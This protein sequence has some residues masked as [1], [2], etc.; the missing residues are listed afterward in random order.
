MKIF[1]G[2]IIFLIIISLVLGQ[3]VS[4]AQQASVLGLPKPGTMVNLSPSY[5][6][7]IVK[8][9]RVHP[10]NPILFDFILDT[11]NS[12]LGV[13]STQLH[14]ESEKLIKY[15]L[16]S[17]T[18]PEDDLWVNLSPYEKK[19][20][21]P[22]QLGQTVMGR[23]MLAEDYILKQLTASLIYPEKD[24]GKKF[25]NRVYTKAQNIF[26]SSD[27]PVN[28]FNK[29]WIVA[30]KA[31]VYVHDNTAFVVAC[32]MKVMLEQDYLSMYKHEQAG[33][34][35][36][37]NAIGSQVVREVVLPELEK[38]VNS[39]KNFANLRQIFN[40]MILAAW[41]KKNLKQALLN[42]VYSNKAKINGID[43]Q[44]KTI[45]EQIYQEYLKAYKKGV[46]NYIK[47]D[48]QAD[49]QTIA[50]KYFSGGEIGIK[51]KD[52]QVVG[53]TDRDAVRFMGN[54]AKGS[55]L[56]VKFMPQELGGANNFSVATLS[57]PPGNIEIDEGDRKSVV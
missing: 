4:Y 36:S 17:L 41:Y 15:F 30:D 10:E 27:I 1:K 26:G 52:V 33:A 20:I 11:G 42:Q 12:G 7:V 22:E 2:I 32:H 38:E 21:I 45:K 31:K 23:D 39:G 25:W 40:S 50:R 53:A 48:V 13:N 18:I 49:G 5:V 56:D 37:A 35:K 28:T 6:P 51:G 57:A 9:L 47:D 8:G 3:P 16:A 46:F 19:R 54:P 55:L 29:V 14:S 34:A 44:D 24:L 43:V